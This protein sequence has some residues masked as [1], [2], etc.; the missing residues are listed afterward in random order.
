MLQTDFRF[1]KNAISIVKSVRLLIFSC[2][3]SKRQ[4]FG[5]HA[6]GTD[7]EENLPTKSRI[8]GKT[9]NCTISL[10]ELFGFYDKRNEK[11]VG[12]E[13]TKL[14]SQSSTISFVVWL[15]TDNSVIA[16]DDSLHCR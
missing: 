9:L 2:E 8:K 11:I 4:I 14:L 16:C 10:H 13:C 1:A 6:F 12:K 15:P 3:H 7:C 5:M